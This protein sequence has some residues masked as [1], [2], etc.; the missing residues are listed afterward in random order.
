MVPGAAGRGVRRGLEERRVSPTVEGMATGLASL[1]VE[2]PV[3]GVTYSFTTP[4][5]QAAITAR[6]I[7]HRSIETT[8][9]LGAVLLAI[10]IGG[11]LYRFVRRG[12]LTGATGSTMLIAVGIVSILSGVLPIAGLVLVIV[13][14]VI[15]SRRRRLEHL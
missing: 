12:V 15:K 11:A 1:P 4:R 2:F 5:G 8:Q 9:R 14:G 7:S 3:R 10:V 13:G 6:A